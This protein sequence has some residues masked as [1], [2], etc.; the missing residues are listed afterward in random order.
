[1]RPKARSQ[2]G[3]HGSGRGRDTRAGHGR[4]HEKPQRPWGPA[5]GLGHAESFPRVGV[6]AVCEVNSHAAGVGRLG[7]SLRAEPT[8]LLK[9]S[10]RVQEQAKVRGDATVFDLSDF[11][12]NLKSSGRVSYSTK[13]F[14]T[15]PLQ[16][17]FLQK[18]S[19]QLPSTETGR[20]GSRGRPGTPLWTGEC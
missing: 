14:S 17:H 2:T 13:A 4:V 10:M 8:R 1:M 16:G 6:G 7:V 5:L 11:I 15:V 18:P 19:M 12:F 9:G 20:Q 3:R